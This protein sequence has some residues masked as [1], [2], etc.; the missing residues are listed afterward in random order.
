MKKLMLAT[1]LSLSGVAAS[2]A[3]ERTLPLSDVTMEYINIEG[4]IQTWPLQ[5]VC[6]DGQ[7]YLL[8][9]GV[10]APNGIA[11]SFKDGKPEQCQVQRS[12]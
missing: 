4:R 8:V 10:T 6:I 5:K 3:P 11:P 12:K 7:A 9:L 1:I 2:A